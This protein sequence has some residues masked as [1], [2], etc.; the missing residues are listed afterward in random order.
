MTLHS[1][2]SGPSGLARERLLSLPGEPLFIAGWHNALMMHFEVGA[3]E[4]QRHVPY[5]LD[6]WEGRAFISLVAFSMRNMRTRGGGKLAALCFRPI[7]THEFLNVRTYVRQGDEWG[8]H[9]LAEW[10]TSRLAVMLGPRTFGLPY[11]HGRIAYRYDFR[12]GRLSGCV[13]DIKRNGKLE[14]SASL[15]TPA[16]FQPCAAG[17]LDEWLMERYTAYNSGNGVRRFFRVWHRPWPQCRA[18]VTLADNSLLTNNWPLFSEARLIGA[19]FSPGFDEVWMGRP[20]RLDRIE[21]SLLP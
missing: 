21:N 3:G 15:D 17:S 7:A 8:I 19:N 9:F 2:T 13:T 1:R 12:N 16:I 20:W 11:R 18:N 5:E 10:L 14:Y 4:L 6:L